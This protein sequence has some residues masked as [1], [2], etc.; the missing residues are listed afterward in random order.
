MYRRNRLSFP[1]HGGA[2]T[3]AIGEAY[4][5][6]SNDFQAALGQD[7]TYRVFLQEEGEGQLYVSDKTGSY[8]VVSGTGSLA[9]SWLAII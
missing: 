2:T 6:L 8:F 1:F 7:G 9:F 4:V 5:Y 3:S